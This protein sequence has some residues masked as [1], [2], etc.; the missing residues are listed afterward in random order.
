MSDHD[1][2]APEDGVSARASA[3]DKLAPVQ[4]KQRRDGRRGAVIASVV[5]VA[6]LLGIG[7]GLV[8]YVRGQEKPDLGAVK[9][10]ED[11]DRD[12]ITSGFTYKQEPPV[13]GKHHPAWANCGIYTKAVKPQHAVH[14]LEHGAVWITY[15]SSLPKKQIQSLEATARKQGDY[16]LV[17]VDDK[18]KSP[19]ALTAWGKQLMVDS[20]SDPTI[21]AFIKKYWKGP[22][23]P[24]P[25]AA[26][27]GAYDPNTDQVA[28]GM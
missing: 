15:N 6:L 3:R 23:T 2:T 11:L 4:R 25:G 9:S 5:A 22:Q 26:C 10:Y 27:S 18:Q 17:S 24:E 20:A 12:H 16:M 7:G 28:G 13:G 19:I 8:A 1:D 21:D 14:S